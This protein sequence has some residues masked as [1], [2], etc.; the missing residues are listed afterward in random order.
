MMVGLV[1][2]SACGPT[3]SGALVTEER[4]VGEFDSIEVSGGIEL[5]LTVDPDSSPLVSVTYDDNIID[6]IRTE[7]DGSTL[8]IDSEGS[9]NI[10]G[11]DGRF[12]EVTV[13]DLQRLV[14]SG[15]TEVIGEGESD[16]LDLEA[17]GGADVD[18]SEI[19]VGD[20]TLQ[21]SGGAN[22]IVTV[23][24]AVTGDASG[25][26]DVVIQGDPPFQSIDT[27]GGADVSGG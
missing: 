12:V 23:T 10:I 6:R 24:D 20:L 14:A 25:G 7:V 18:L 16:L 26:A 8:R 22:V 1:L 11:G 17:S 4:E 3:G 13:T 2:L 19:T 27:S 15:G 21:A 9:F 5:R